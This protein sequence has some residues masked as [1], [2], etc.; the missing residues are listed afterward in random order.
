MSVGKPKMLST[1]VKVEASVGCG[2]LFVFFSGNS[3]M[4][5]HDVRGGTTGLLGLVGL[6]YNQKMLLLMDTCS[7]AVDFLVQV[8][9]SANNVL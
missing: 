1:K 2:G 6:D 8:A 3:M 4:F 7:G 5:D 9:L